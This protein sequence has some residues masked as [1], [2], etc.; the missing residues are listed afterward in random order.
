MA[1]AHPQRGTA[2]MATP[3][4]SQ[5]ISRACATPFMDTTVFRFQAHGCR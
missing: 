2:E 3:P 4:A 1:I 5:N